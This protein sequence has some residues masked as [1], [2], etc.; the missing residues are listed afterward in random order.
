M[1]PAVL[2]LLKQGGVIM[3]LGLGVVF[4]LLTV[5]VFAVYGMSY[6]A[7]LID[8]PPLT[9]A[10]QTGPPAARNDDPDV[11]AAITA[12]V[13]QHRRRTGAGE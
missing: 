11:V 7:G 9:P 8:E 3:M 13:H 12:A 6:V 5:L 1:D 4:S 2:E 10:V